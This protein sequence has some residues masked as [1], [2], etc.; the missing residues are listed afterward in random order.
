MAIS[1]FI[2]LATNPL[3]FLGNIVQY[4]LVSHG[5]AV[6]GSAVLPWLEISLA[7]MLLL[8]IE[9]KV[10]FAL[11][12]ILALLFIGA[13]ASAL[14]RGLSI[15]CGCFGALTQRSI[16][17]ESLSLAAAMLLSAVTGFLFS[18]LYQRSHRFLGKDTGTQQ[19]P[20]IAS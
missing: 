11:S 3:F 19:A 6:L 7:A 18:S 8:N 5:V 2:W 12:S 17:A 20:G 10:S 15:D 1:A 16:G 4:D 13:Q 14:M 9:R